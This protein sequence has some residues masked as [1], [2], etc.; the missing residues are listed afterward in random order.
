MAIRLDGRNAAA[1]DTK[2]AEEKIDT[3]AREAVDFHGAALRL[4]ATRSRDAICSEE[5]LLHLRLRAILTIVAS[6]IDI[7][8]K[9]TC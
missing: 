3:M 8:T 1:W 9:W 7:R 2:M 5:V 4:R 6:E